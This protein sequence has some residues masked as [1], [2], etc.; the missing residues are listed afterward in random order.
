MKILIISQYYPPES[1]FVPATI[2][3]TLAAQG[4]Q[5]KVLTG[6][7]NYPDGRLYDGHTQRWRTR[8]SDGPIDVLRVPLWIDHSQ[9]AVRRTLN[10]VSFGLS[11]STAFDFARDADVIYVY[12]TQ[13]TPALAPWFW[14]IMGGASYVLHVQDLWPDSITGSSLVGGGRGAGVVD[15]LLTPWL[16]SVYRHAAAVIGIAPTMVDTLVERGVDPGKAHLVYNWADEQPLPPVPAGEGETPRQGTSILYAGNVGDMQDLETAVQ[17]AHRSRDA[18]VRLTI[19]GDGVALPRVRALAE[20]LGATNVA[21][22]GRLPIER[23]GDYYRAA[24]F[25]LVSLKDLPAFRGTIPSKFQAS[26]AHG[27]PV[28]T[29]VQGD[30]RAFVDEHRVG[31]TANAEAPASLESAF[32]AAAALG[33]QARD[34]MAA[35]ARGAYLDH[36]SLDAGIAAVEQILINAARPTAQ[37]APTVATKGTAH[38]AS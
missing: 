37:Q 15:A 22:E 4:H 18:G 30:V 19:V 6:Y 36:F 24:D 31:F 7:P 34:E 35:R 20:Q 23:M 10:Y 11:A 1:A 8:E 13:M 33:G 27:L 9:S 29:T 17:A 12:A 2:A 28:V 5:V 32:R 3:R 25:A 38:A 16:A 14:R 21:F 26:L